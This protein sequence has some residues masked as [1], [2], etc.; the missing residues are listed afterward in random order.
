MGTV[1]A[2][3]WD[4]QMMCRARD[5]DIYS[6]SLLLERYHKPLISFLQRMVGNRFEAEEL[7]QE[8]FLR[9]YR[10]RASYQPTAKFT[11][12]LFR[13]ATHAAI[14]SLRNGR[15]ERLTESLD[16]IEGKTIRREYSDRKPNIEQA[17]LARAS[18][19]EVRNA[20]N[21]LPANQRTAVIMHKYR[22]WE[23][24]RIANELHCSESAVK[25]LLYR[26]Y[27]RLRMNLAH[28]SDATHHVSA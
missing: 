20:I 19:Q 8:V 14:N 18:A 13:I 5:G 2:G 28:L 24:S 10:S 21:R 25:S 3:E 17:L 6:F 27:E 15:H 11:T 23:Y 7:A 22:E 26:A 12:W 16:Q 9:L 1:Y 4:V